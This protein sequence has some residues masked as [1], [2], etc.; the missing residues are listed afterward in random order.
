MDTQERLHALDALRAFA[1]FLGIYFHASLSY[2]PS[3]EE[4]VVSDTSS[5]FLITIVSGF[6]HLFRMALFFFI[7]GY[8]AR[9]VY[10]RKGRAYFI[11]DRA[12]RIALPLLIFLPIM[13][14]LLGVI[15]RWGAQD[16]GIT[17]VL[18]PPL[19]VDN[20]PLTHLWFLYYLFG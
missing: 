16:K 20:F 9:L 8:F 4:W 10:H 13:L 11:R 12:K 1:L 5:S 14:P 2:L 7:A 15:W 17:I 18:S 19:T 6:S 3:F